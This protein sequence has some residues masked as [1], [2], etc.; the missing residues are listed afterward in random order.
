MGA[1]EQV[2]F[3]KSEDE[4][5][6]SLSYSIGGIATSTSFYSEPGYVVNILINDMGFRTSYVFE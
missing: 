4:R 2:I 6:I 5:A 3:E 1:A